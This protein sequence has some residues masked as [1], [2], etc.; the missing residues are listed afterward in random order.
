MPKMKYAYYAVVAVVAVA[1][2]SAINVFKPDTAVKADREQQE[3]A[4]EMLA[5]ADKLSEEAKAAA[6]QE[7]G[8]ASC[9]ERV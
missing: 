9:R 7:I 1:G 5:Q 6:A 3:E 2:L 8:R 4:R